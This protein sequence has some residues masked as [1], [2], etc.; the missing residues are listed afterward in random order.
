MALI[1]DKNQQVMLHICCVVLYRFRDINIL[2]SLVYLEKVGHVHEI[3]LLQWR[4]SMENIKIYK[5]IIKYFF[6]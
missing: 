6:S 3:L 1:D 4:R 5:S 2:N